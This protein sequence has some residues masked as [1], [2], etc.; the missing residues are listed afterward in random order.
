[1]KKKSKKSVRKTVR[2]VTKERKTH[3]R[4]VG[5]VPVEAPVQVEKV[6]EDP[7]LSVEDLADFFKLD[8][9]T[10]YRKVKDGT[11]PAIRIGTGEHAPVRFRKSEID[12]M[13]NDTDK[14]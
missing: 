8:V 13:L 5:D 3:K 14:E 7:L 1:M 11:I 2:K 9:Q 4:R 12:K 6:I 10:I